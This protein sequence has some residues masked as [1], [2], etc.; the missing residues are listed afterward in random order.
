MILYD[1]KDRYNTIFFLDILI[2]SL[3]P[4]GGNLS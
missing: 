1:A 4:Y 2:T 3:S